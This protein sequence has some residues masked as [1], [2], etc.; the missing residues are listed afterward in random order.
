MQ[1]LIVLTLGLLLTSNVSAD[2]KRPTTY[3]HISLSVSA[4]K[5]VANDR[6]IAELYSEREGEEVSRI[7]SQVNESITWALDLA[8]SVQNVTA[9]TTNYFSQ[10]VYREQ[11]VVGWRVRQSIKLESQDATQLSQLIG[12]LQERLA[13]GSL[14]Y[15]LSPGVRTKAEDEL[16]TQALA[17]FQKRAQLITE[18]LGRSSFRIVQVDV[19]TAGAPIQPR[20]SARMAAMEAADSPAPPA[21]ESGVQLVHV[22]VNGTIELKLN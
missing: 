9:Q 8:R 2:D 21:I 18:Q 1:R 20:H 13:I 6:I 15:N 19:I 16:I 17:S 10:P 14:S 3:D 22:R 5:P 11:T 12:D 7:A 4:E